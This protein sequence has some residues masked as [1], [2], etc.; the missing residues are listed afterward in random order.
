MKNHKIICLII[1][2]PWPCSKGLNK[3]VCEVESGLYQ[4]ERALAP[5]ALVFRCMGRCIDSMVLFLGDA[6]HTR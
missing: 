1:L 2:N 4:F 3:T 5:D 6:Y